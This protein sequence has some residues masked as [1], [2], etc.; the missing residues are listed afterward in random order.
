[1][2]SDTGSEMIQRVPTTVLMVDDHRGF[3]S[4]ARQLLEASG[5]AVIGES[6]SGRSA[7]ADNDRLHPDL[8]L[9]DIQLPDIDG[10]EV[11]RLLAGAEHS[12]AVV[13]ISSRDAVEYGELL[14]A[15]PAR[16]FLSKR[17]LDG[18]ALAALL[19]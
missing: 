14:S 2:T 8:V 1:M 4:A 15:A 11:A 9:L 13:L 18:A 5:F 10:F 16:G 12:P 3:R 19:V 17:D 6:A 7:V